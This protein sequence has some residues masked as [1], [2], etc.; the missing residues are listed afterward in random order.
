[1]SNRT[2]PGCSRGTIVMHLAG[3]TVSQSHSGSGSFRRVSRWRLRNRD[4][5]GLSSSRIGRSSALG[6]SDPF[7][8]TKTDPHEEH[9]LERDFAA[10]QKQASDIIHAEGVPFSTLQVRLA[11]GLPRS[12]D[13]LVSLVVSRRWGPR[14]WGPRSWGPRRWGPVRRAL[15]DQGGIGARPNILNAA[16]NMVKDRARRHRDE[17]CYQA[18]FGQVLTC[19]AFA[20]ESEYY[21][22][23]MPH[24][25]S[26][27]VLL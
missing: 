17:G 14:S 22:K 3:Q 10:G 25:S 18:V 20:K 27:W 21:T 19:V 15:G 6:K 13:R 9:D 12:V 5:S 26:T 23:P 1:M 4:R 16:R 2:G 24:F 7:P 8:L 11:L